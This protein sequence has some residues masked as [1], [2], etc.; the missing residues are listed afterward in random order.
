V[1]QPL[2]YLDLIETFP[3]PGCAVC[4]LVL[5]DA[6][7]F[8][9]GLLYESVNLPETHQAFRAAR[10]LCNT[11]SWQL[12]RYTGYSLGIS[13]LYRAVLDEVLTLLDQASDPQPGLA[14]LWGGGAAADASKLADHLEPSAPCLACKVM[15]DAE[16]RYLKMLGQHL[17]QPLE[18][19]YRASDG[20]CLPHFRQA[21]RQTRAPEQF[22]SLIAL[23][24]AIWSKLKAD[25]EEFADKTDYRRAHEPMGAER[26]SWQRAVGRM[27]GEKGVFSVNPRW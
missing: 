26:D 19:A 6:D 1:T 25:L 5:R 20:L 22:R 9:D 17:D 15:G 14:R 24:R 27:A 23:Q 11:H 21:L 7:R 4:N 8:L 18:A 10:G 16:Q 3:R 13:I 12:L 2:S